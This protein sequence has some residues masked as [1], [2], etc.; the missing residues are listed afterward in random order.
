MKNLKKNLKP[1]LGVVTILS[2]V[3]YCSSPTETFVKDPRDYSWSV[4]TIKNE[5]QGALQTM[6][7][8][9]WGSS[10]NDVYACGHTDIGPEIY[11]YDGENWSAIDLRDYGLKNGICNKVFGFSE[12][13]VWIAGG[14][15]HGYIGNRYINSNLIHFDGSE[16]ENYEF[17]TKSEL[18]D[19]WGT[20]SE[21]LWACGRNGLVIHREGQVWDFDTVSIEQI[22]GDYELYLYSIREFNSE[23]F[24]V[25]YRYPDP[26]YLVKRTNGNW[27]V[28]DSVESGNEYTYGTTGLFVSKENKF[29]SHGYKGLFKY[30]GNT[31]EKIIAVS[32]SVSGMVE[33]A[34]NKLLVS[35]FSHNL[36]LLENDSYEV[37]KQTESDYI[38]F[39]NV[40][41]NNEECFVLCL[42]LSVNWGGTLVYHG[43]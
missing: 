4:D 24:V 42:D 27:I 3:V 31:W 12:N 5:D 43:K 15:G 41:G 35:E 14:L 29:Y 7:Q 11:H 18:T 16:W 1:V 26:Y 19:V 34:K 13:D 28:V 9:I 20:S 6:L 32:S 38:H 40:W 25:G 22:Y 10:P 36:Y 33:F 2:V 30:T 17:E 39:T 21:D 37:I 8:S 23:V